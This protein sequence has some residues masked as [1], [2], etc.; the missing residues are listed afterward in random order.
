MFK[1]VALSFSPAKGDTPVRL[2]HK[3]SGHCSISVGLEKRRSEE[4][5]KLIVPEV[6]DDADGPVGEEETTRTVQQSHK[7]F[8][9]QQIHC[10]VD[11]P[12]WRKGGSPYVCC[13][14]DG[15]LVHDLRRHVFRRAAFAVLLFRRVQFDGVA[16][17]ADADLVAGGTCHQ[18]IFG[19]EGG[20][21]LAVDSDKLQK[22]ISTDLDVEVGDVLLV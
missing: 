10:V 16:E 22:I 5:N 9:T 15:S 2:K 21:G 18:N 17:V 3:R 20:A 8:I 7:G 19:L 14:G 11:S 1:A 6:S 12:P 13:C 4:R